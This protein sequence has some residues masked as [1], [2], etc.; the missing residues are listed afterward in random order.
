ME[1][2]VIASIVLVPLFL[3]DN[4]SFTVMVIITASISRNSTRIIGDKHLMLRTMI[5]IIQMMMI[6]IMIMMSMLIMMMMVM[7]KRKVMAMMMMNTQQI[8]MAFL[9]LMSLA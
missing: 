1:T 8:S 5:L 3:R 7:T 2:L 4:Y 6:L 9:P